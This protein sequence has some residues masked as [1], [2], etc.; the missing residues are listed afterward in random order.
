M[1]KVATYPLVGAKIGQSWVV[2]Y[3][4]GATEAIYTYQDFSIDLHSYTSKEDLQD[5]LMLNGVLSSLVKEACYCWKSYQAYLA[6]KDTDN[7]QGLDYDRFAD[8]EVR[9]Y[10]G[11]IR[12]LTRNTLSTINKLVKTQKFNVQLEEYTTILQTL[13]HYQMLEKA[14]NAIDGTEEDVIL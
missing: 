4:S 11:Q 12:S 1:D 10:D 6:S 3:D 7:P 2:V 14:Q 8:D 5:H 9:S 13:L